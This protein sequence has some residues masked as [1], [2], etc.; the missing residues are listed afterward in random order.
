MGFSLKKDTAIGAFL[1]VVPYREERR[2]QNDRVTSSGVSVRT[3]LHRRSG[4][5]SPILVS[6]CYTMVCPPV[7]GDK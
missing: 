1:N 7:R 3:H 2:K 4:N 5:T 6:N